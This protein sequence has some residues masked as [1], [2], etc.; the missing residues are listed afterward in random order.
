MF[1]EAVDATAAAV[2]AAATVRG[3]GS[4]D[5][6]RN[7]TSVTLLTK[8]GLGYITKDVMCELLQSTLSKNKCLLIKL[9]LVVI[10]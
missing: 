9:V 7:S 6:V 10:I 1:A 3:A 8:S 2:V 5:G 4:G